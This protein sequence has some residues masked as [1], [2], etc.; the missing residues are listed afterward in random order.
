MKNIRQ[1]KQGMIIVFTLILL[2]VFLTTALSASYFIIGDINKARAIDDSV[3]AYYAADAGMEESLFLLN[4]QEIAGSLTGLKSI[5]PAG[6][7]LP[8]SN[9]SWSIAD[10]VAYEKMALRQ[11]IH[12]GQSAKFFILNRASIESPNPA[13]SLTV[14]WYK[15][16]AGAPK[17]QINFTQLTPQSQAGTLIYYQDRSEMEIADTAAN[18]GYVRCYNF[19]D[20]DLAGQALPTPTDYLTEFKVLG[21]TNDFVDRL[22]VKV[23]NKECGAADYDESWNR[24]GIT[25]LTVKSRGS[26]GKSQQNIVAQILPK[27]PVSGV[28]SFVLFSEQDV[29]KE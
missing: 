10:S 14:E 1:N 17:L 8:A 23:Y 13:R 21:A 24:E 3:I 6:G 19:R 16:Q 15:G 11:R 5:R 2:A 12:N 28:L 9:S 7:T 18:D 29:T 26:Y 4:K 20:I 22:L 25:N 27:D